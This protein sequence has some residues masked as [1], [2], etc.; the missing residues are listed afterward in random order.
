[1]FLYQ[2]KWQ[3]NIQLNSILERM[4]QFGGGMAAKKVSLSKIF[5][6]YPTM[7]KLETAIP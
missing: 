6:T 1:M 4:G 5:H 3:S 2:F 7:M